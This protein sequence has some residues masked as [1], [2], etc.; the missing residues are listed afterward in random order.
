MD[1][2][3]AELPML[4]PFTPGLGHD[5]GAAIAGFT[6]LPLRRGQAVGTGRQTD[7]VS[8]CCSCMDIDVDV[9]SDDGTDAGGV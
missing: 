3:G 9:S 6:C 8:G 7:A 2:G 1:T 4:G 5:L